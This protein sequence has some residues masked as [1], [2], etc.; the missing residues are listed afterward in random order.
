MFI[1]FKSL[2]FFKLNSEEKQVISRLQDTCYWVA[3][4]GA[5]GLTSLSQSIVFPVNRG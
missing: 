1:Y 5:F 4:F 2:G 3:N